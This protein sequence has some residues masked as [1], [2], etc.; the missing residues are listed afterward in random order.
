[1]EPSLEELR[2]LVPPRG[3][4]EPRIAPGRRADIGALNWIVAAVAGRVA[5]TGPMNIF[6][7]LGRHRSLFRRWLIFA[8]AL[9]P[10][11]KLPRA[12]SELVILRVAVNTGAA[13][14]WH[15]HVLLGQKAGLPADRIAA[16][17]DGPT[18]GGWTPRQEA[19]LHCCDELH[20]VQLLSD[21]TWAE[22]R[23]AGLSDR[24]LVELLMLVGAYE[25]L[26]MALNGLGVQVERP[27]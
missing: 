23:A 20:A 1:M 2:A 27:R 4:A 10:G 21:E 8:G 3:P 22:L 15:Q 16:V 12:D 14:E 17:V 9:M 26:A 6:T 25:G 24:D 11:G 13:Y 19:L 18:A 5:G 7:T